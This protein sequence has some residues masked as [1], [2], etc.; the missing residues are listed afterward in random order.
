[1]LKKLLLNEH[2]QLAA[3]N[4][5]IKSTVKFQGYKAGKFQ[6]S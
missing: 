1:M 4:T 3:P 6:K 5:H 2:I